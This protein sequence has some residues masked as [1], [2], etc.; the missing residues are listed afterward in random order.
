MKFMTIQDILLV[1]NTSNKKHVKKLEQ[2]TS[3]KAKDNMKYKEKKIQT[4]MYKKRI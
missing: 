4:R 2:K 3:K 1:K